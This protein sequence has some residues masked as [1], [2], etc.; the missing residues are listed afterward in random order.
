MINFTASKY[1]A[2]P[3]PN[4]LNSELES[5]IEKGSVPVYKRVQGSLSVKSL[6][7]PV[8]VAF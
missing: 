8:D 7:I 6:T 4:L 2:Y 3:T 1:I 5:Q